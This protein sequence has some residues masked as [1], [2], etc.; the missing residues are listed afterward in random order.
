MTTST[1]S[2]NASV[3]DVLRLTGKQRKPFSRSRRLRD[4]PTDWRPLTI[5]EQHTLAR[6]PEKVRRRLSKYCSLNGKIHQCLKFDGAV[7]TYR[8]SLTHEQI[9]KLQ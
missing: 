7:Y 4:A 3:Q 6:Q 8:T 9:K 5:Y 2:S 1:E